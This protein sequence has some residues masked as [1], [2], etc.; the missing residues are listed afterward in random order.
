MLDAELALWTK[1]LES[2]VLRLAAAL[3]NPDAQGEE[4][5]TTLMRIQQRVEKLR[6]ALVARA[7]CRG[8]SWTRLGRVLNL[9]KDTVRRK[10]HDVDRI[11]R[12]IVRPRATP[13]PTADDDGD[14]P[15]TPPPS[16]GTEGVPV[17]EPPPTD[18]LAPVLSKLQRAS[19]LTLRAL[20]ERAKIST[21]YLSR[22]LSGERFP[23]W[24][25]TARIARASGADPSVLRTVW[26]A[27]HQQRDH[28]QAPHSLDSA[29]RYLHHRAGAPSLWS[30]A[31]ASGG[32]LD[33]DLV[34]AVLDGSV[35]PDWETVRRL[36]LVLDGEPSFFTPLWEKVSDHVTEPPTPRIPTTP[37]HPRGAHLEEMLHAFR[38]TLTEEPTSPAGTAM[39]TRPMPRPI[40]ALSTLATALGT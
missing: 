23:D 17:I 22:I 2:E 8:V 27:A 13:A 24:N 3:E 11:V 6:P 20:G 25:T 4:P 15:R 39:R 5:L 10:Y 19:Q 28:R 1:S 9:N 30:I 37:Q 36:V 34:A 31:V 40:P 33:Q 35:V 18:Q 7:R 16:A 38:E 21:S 29:L 26:E 12:G 32:N 14:S